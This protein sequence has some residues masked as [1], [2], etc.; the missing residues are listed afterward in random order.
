MQFALNIAARDDHRG[1]GFQAPPQRAATHRYGRL[2]AP[3]GLALVEDFLN[4]GGGGDVSDLLRHP[5]TASD[6]VA[7]ALDSWAVEM[8]IKVPALEL[9]EADL[10]SACSLRD[11]L[12][13][14]LALGWVS[15]THICSGPGEFRLGSDGVTWNPT[16]TGWQGLYGL[17]LGEVF[18][19]HRD[20][21]WKRL[22]VCAEESCQVAFYDR[23]WDN[24]E[25]F[26]NGRV[27]QRAAPI[28]ARSVTRC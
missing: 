16:A 1:R 11:H 20:G 4:T 8:G 2:P 24:R 18:L 5:T 13:D 14:A 15:P 25:R 3:S 22:K 23:T 7:T 12:R 17:V 26:H 21:T 10:P 9:T 6:W 27:C 28:T 19:A